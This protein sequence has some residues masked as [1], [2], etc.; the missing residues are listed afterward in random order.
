MACACSITVACRVPAFGVAL[1]VAAVDADDNHIA[2]VGRFQRRNRA[3]GYRPVATDD[4]FH[5]GV[6]LQDA[7]HDAFAVDQG[8][9]G[10]L[11]RHADH[12]RILVNDLME[13]FRTG[14]AVIIGRLQV[15]SAYLP[16][17][18]IFSTKTLA[19]SEPAL[20]VIV[21]NL[22]QCHIINRNFAVN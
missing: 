3:K 4:A 21:G 5:V 15:S 19:T 14:D 18:A 17:S 6:R 9:F 10:I 22:F 13:R 2:T 11:F 8:A 1:I 16:F 12:I 7:V 20:E